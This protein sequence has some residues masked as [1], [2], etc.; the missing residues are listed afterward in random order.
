MSLSAKAQRSAD[1]LWNNIVFRNA[2]MSFDNVLMYGYLDS[3]SVGNSSFRY[4]NE[5]NGLR[6]A[7]MARRTDGFAVHSEQYVEHKQ[8]KF[9]GNFLFSKYQ[10]LESKYTEMANPYRD[11]PYKIVDSLGGDWNKQYY[12]LQAN[13]VAPTVKEHTE[14]GMGITYK[15]LNGARQKDPR[16]LDKTVIITLTPSVLY[17]VTPSLKLGVNGYYS[18]YNEDL[19]VSL[20]NTQ[21]S[22]NIYKTLGSGEYLYN[23]PILL[24]VGLSRSYIGN[25]YGGGLSWRY[26]WGGGSSLDGTVS[27][28]TTREKVTDGTSTPYNAGTHKNKK[29]DVGLA[30]HLP[31]ERVEHILT[32]NGIYAKNSDIEY[33]QVL[34]SSTKLY[35]VIFSSEMHKKESANLQAKYIGL[36]KGEDG[37]LAWE[38]HGS[39]VYQ[40]FSEDYPSSMGRE[41]V[42]NMKMEL[43]GRKWFRLWEGSLSISYQLGYR[44]NMDESI[45]YFPKVGSSNFVAYNILYPNHYFNTANILNNHVA[46]QYDFRQLRKRNSIPYIRVSFENQRGMSNGIY[47]GDGTNNNYFSVSLGIFN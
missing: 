28:K 43:G 19:S 23:G 32:L 26:F 15:V 4:F 24:G 22:Q 36:W 29:W 21:R 25:T 40:H 38:L 6:D 31:T 41:S 44:L 11:N 1:S 9:Y 5:N 20:E 10:D 17:A 12:L 18:H 16:P 34:N 37:A 39:A 3:G 14:I 33:V 30:Y 46:L 7:Y 2:S 45:V 35:D 47:L 42:S 27:Y 13:I 8:W